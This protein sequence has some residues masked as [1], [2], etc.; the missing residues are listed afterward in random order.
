MSFKLYTS[1]N[2]KTDDCVVRSISKVTNTPYEV[3][4]NELEECR[5]LLGKDDF[6]N[7]YVWKVYL[8][9]IKNYEYIPIV[10]KHKLTGMEFSDNYKDGL[11]ILHMVKLY[12]SHLTTCIYGTIYDTFDCSSLNVYEAW[13]I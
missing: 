11:Y 9:N 1:T 13:K 10:P 6:R 3:I 2:N 8:S 4:E 7:P 5:Q 12:N